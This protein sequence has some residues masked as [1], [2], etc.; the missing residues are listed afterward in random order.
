M[1]TRHAFLQVKAQPSHDAGCYL[2]SR[3]KIGNH[4]AKDAHEGKQEDEE[5]RYNT[6][7]QEA[8]EHGLG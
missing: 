3:L 6:S 4:V 1:T 5:A 2:R 8:D 7:Q